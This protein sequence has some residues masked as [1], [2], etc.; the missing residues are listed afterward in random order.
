MAIGTSVS[1]R[2]DHSMPPYL[3]IVDSGCM[4]TTHAGMKG[5]SV[6]VDDDDE[7]CSRMTRRW[8]AG[9]TN[10]FDLRCGLNDSICA[11]IEF[12]T[13][14][15]TSTLVKDLPFIVDKSVDGVSVVSM[16]GD[17]TLESSF[18][19]VTVGNTIIIQAPISLGDGVC[20]VDGRVIECSEQSMTI[21]WTYI[22]MC[23]NE[24]VGCVAHILGG[25]NAGFYYGREDSE[26]GPLS[27]LF[28][29]DDECD[30][31]P[32]GG[33]AN[34]VIRIPSSRSNCDSFKW[35][36][37][38]V[39]SWIMYRRWPYFRRVIDSG[40][41]EAATSILTLPPE[42]PPK[43]LESLIHFLY[44]GMHL[45]LSP[46]DTSPSERVFINEYAEML[47]FGVDELVGFNPLRKSI[48]PVAQPVSFAGL[49]DFSDPGLYS[50]VF[51]TGTTT[52]SG[53]TTNSRTAMN[54]RRDANTASTAHASSP[55]RRSSKKRRSSVGKNSCRRRSRGR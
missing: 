25:P 33:T 39:H 6:Y 10:F 11:M 36:C 7:A 49:V 30:A 23:E 37:V 4:T 17:A 52:V 43:L 51:L 18:G 38:L 48:V 54:R 24:S 9:Q 2:L 13:G 35:R 31:D 27:C 20:Y 45:V 55:R 46:N 16:L 42:F 12:D 40:M 53:S 5:V 47:G 22:P 44:T 21:E 50:N 41:A 34:F 32:F 15:I 8:S 14:V 1:N 19:Q 3:R 28:M 26:L 29:D